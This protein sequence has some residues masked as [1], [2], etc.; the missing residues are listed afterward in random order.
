M[1]AGGEPAPGSP[2]YR[3]RLFVAGSSPLS[4]RTIATL[5]GLCDRLLP[6]QVDLEVV[7]IYQ[8]PALAVRDQVVA[9]PTLLKLSPDPVRRMVGDLS[10]ERR[11]L[12]ALGLAFP[13]ETNGR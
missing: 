10:D 1:T 5:R 13:S 6:G 2:P 7:D 8:Q 4:V 11:V 3:L 12:R 9:A